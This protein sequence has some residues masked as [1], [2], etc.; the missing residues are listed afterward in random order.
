MSI[1]ATLWTLKFPHQGR[2]HLDCD[3]VR[4]RAQGVPS[5]IGSPTPGLGYEDGDPYDAFLPP[6]LET[7][8]H[9]EHEFTRAVVFVTEQTS[10][11]TERS[12]Q[13][14]VDPLLVQTG[15]AYA[16]LTFEELHRHLC[17]ALRDYEPQRYS[18]D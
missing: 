9:G 8:K 2:A 17:D 4:V 10:K 6:P 13:E 3:W 1:Y 7:D 11:G 12:P 18:T 14:Y 16:R 5:H 15:E